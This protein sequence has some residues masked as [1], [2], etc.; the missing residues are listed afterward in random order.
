MT[1]R[2]ILGLA[3]LVPVALAAMFYGYGRPIWGPIYVKLTGGRTVEE[4]MTRIGPRAEARLRQRFEAAGAAYPPT[5][6]TLIGLKHEKRLELWA[7]DGSGMRLV[8]RYPILGASGG[9]GPKLRQGDRQVPEGLYRIAALNPNSSYHLSMKVD[10]PHADDLAHAEAEG[11]DD[12]GG[13]IFIHGKTG[14]VGCLAMGDPAIEELFCVVARVGV[15]RVELILAPND[16]R[17]GSAATDMSDA[18]PWLADRY[19]RIAAAMAAYRPPPP[20]GPTSSP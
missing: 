15:E 19:R 10:Y 2:V 13:D 16:L 1:R 14:S 12:P 4:V 20:D 3:A 11:R 6:L 8:H 7:D 5:R 9:P 17:A 18:P